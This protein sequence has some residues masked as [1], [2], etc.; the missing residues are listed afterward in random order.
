MRAFSDLQIKINR[1]FQG[2]RIK[3]EKLEGDEIVIKDYEVRASKLKKENDPNW[4]GGRGE[5][6]YLQIERNGKEYVLWGNYKFLIE[7]IKQVP[8]ESLPIKATIINEHGYIFR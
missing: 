8:I 6:L 3:I 7:Q 1:R 4:S 2:D 5:C